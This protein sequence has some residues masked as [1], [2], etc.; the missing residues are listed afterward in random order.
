M[1]YVYAVWAVTVLLSVSGCPSGNVSEP[2]VSCYK[3]LPSGG[4]Q[5]DANLCKPKKKE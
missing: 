5:Y 2:K 3:T 1:K 4:T